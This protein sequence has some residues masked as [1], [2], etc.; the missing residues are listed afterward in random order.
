MERKDR[1]EHKAAQRGKRMVQGLPC[2]T[3]PDPEGTMKDRRW[4]ELW[5][6]MGDSLRTRTR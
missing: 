1:S 4:Q 3:P 2:T 6:A 5:N